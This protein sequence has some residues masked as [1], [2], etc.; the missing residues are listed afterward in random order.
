MT[1]EHLLITEVG[2]CEQGTLRMIPK[3]QQG[4]NY[5][6]N[7]ASLILRAINIVDKYWLWQFDRG[8]SIVADEIDVEE[9]EFGT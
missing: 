9:L 3:E 6:G 5:M 8:Y 4:V 7:H 1:E 2:H